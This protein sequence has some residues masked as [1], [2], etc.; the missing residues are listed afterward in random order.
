MA[1]SCNGFRGLG[2]ATGGPP[3]PCS[4][5]Q[6]Y[7]PAK[8]AKCMKYMPITQGPAPS[9]LGWVFDTVDQG[10]SSVSPNPDGTCPAP[11]EML[12][13]AEPA[14]CVDAMP[15][16]PSFCQPGKGIT[17]PSDYSMPLPTI[18]PP[19]LPAPVVV[20]SSA[21]IDKTMLYVGIG[22]VALVG[23]GALWYFYENGLLK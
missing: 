5:T 17:C 8:P 23:I 1:C 15:L 16:P 19:P 22:A 10:P 21:K 12:I 11:Y 7:I 14:R 13:P 6:A 20:T 4:P 3:S 9:G 18:N 2:Y